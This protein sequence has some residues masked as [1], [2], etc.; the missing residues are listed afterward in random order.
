MKIRRR[1]PRPHAPRF[2]LARLLSS[3]GVTLGELSRRT[4]I[5]RPLLSAYCNGHTL[6]S[7]GQMWAIADELGA[8]LGDFCP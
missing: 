6:P 5:T 4:G 1:N 2:P 3:R 7:W 8:T